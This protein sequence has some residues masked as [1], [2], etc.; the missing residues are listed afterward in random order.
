M[1]KI[2]ASLCVRTLANTHLFSM[3]LL[4]KKLEK[5]NVREKMLQPKME[6]VLCML[7]LFSQAKNCQRRNHPTNEH[8]DVLHS[9]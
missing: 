6:Y 7:L 3:P 2:L 8:A 9:Q 1:D 4:P 5:K